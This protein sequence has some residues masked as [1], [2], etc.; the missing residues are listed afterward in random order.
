MVS[1]WHFALER[2]G[3]LI[4]RYPVE[5]SDDD[6]Y[7]LVSAA[8]EY[9]KQQYLA[10]DEVRQIFDDLIA[11]LEPS[12]AVFE[13]VEE[14]LISGFP[15]LNQV[16]HGRWI[17]L[18]W[19]EG[20]RRGRWSRWRVILEDF[21]RQAETAEAELRIAYGVCLRRLSDWGGAQEAFARVV[22]EFWACWTLRRAGTGASRMEY[23]RQIS[24]GL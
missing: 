14:V 12:K 9:V 20:I 23:S 22:R 7:I 18:L 3:A 19:R 21:M 8:R 4:R 24:G 11:R 1:I 16:Q 2:I 17:S 15:Q 6:E 13:L 5:R 10:S